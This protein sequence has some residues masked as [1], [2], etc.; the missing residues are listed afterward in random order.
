MFASAKLWFLGENTFRDCPQTPLPS[1]NYMFL[2]LGI[3]DILDWM[4]LR[5]REPDFAL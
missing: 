4:I 5:C 3:V 1:L 2:K